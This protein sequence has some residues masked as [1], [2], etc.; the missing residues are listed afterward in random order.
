[1]EIL[2]DKYEFT[3]RWEPFFLR[4]DTPPEGRPKPASYPDLSNPRVQA[5]LQTG[6]AVGIDFTYKCP[7][8]PSTLKSHALMDYAKEKNGGIHQNDVAE[9]LFKKYFTDG[10]KLMED[11][12]LGVAEEAG[13]DRNEVTAHINNQEVLQGV[14]QTASQWSMQGVSGVPTFFINGKQVFSGA[15]DVNAFVK[16]FDTINERFP[17]KTDSKN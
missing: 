7:V 9:K 4:S 8:F 12:V 16:M 13:F 15:Q 1:M 6:K 2:K 17:L 14:L 11:T 10:D 5:L 3:V